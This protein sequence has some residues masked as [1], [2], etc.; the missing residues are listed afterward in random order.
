[1][2]L[3]NQLVSCLPD[4][5]HPS[6]PSYIVIG[7]NG[8]TLYNKL[9]N[10]VERPDLTGPSFQQN[11]HRVAKQA[12]ID[13]GISDWT[14]KRSTKEVMDIL[15]AAGIPVGRV[16][17]VKDIVEGEQIQAR[18]A[19]QEAWVQGN[20]ETKLDGWNI[21]MTGTFPVLEGVDPKPKWA[22]PDLGYHTDEVLR[23]DLGLTDLEINNLR[24]D[25][26]IG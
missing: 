11:H 19:V 4:P 21:K 13:G 25:G 22:G 3:S 2:G 16:V 8:D 14:R 15:T 10:V 7:A 24:K 18:G 23:G 26:I 17:S 1:M 6:L 5:E 9:M 20:E 12:E